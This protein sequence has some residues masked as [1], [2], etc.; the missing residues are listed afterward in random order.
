MSK[1][2]VLED[3]VN[4]PP[5]SVTPLLQVAHKQIM[6][7][8]SIWNPSSVGTLAFPQSASF[9]MRKLSFKE[10]KLGS[11][12]GPEAN[13]SLNQGLNPTSLAPGTSRVT[14]DSNTLGWNCTVTSTPIKVLSTPQ[15]WAQVAPSPRHLPDFV[16]PL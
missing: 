1:S 5:F 3:E 8:L 4:N 14:P 13:K 12:S 15:G 10:V 11:S 6:L 9:W 16:S 7:L 2:S